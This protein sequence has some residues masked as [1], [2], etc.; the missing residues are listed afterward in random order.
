MVAKGDPGG[1]VCVTDPQPDVLRTP[2]SPFQGEVKSRNR[3]R[4]RVVWLIVA[5]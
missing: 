1:S 4:N 3:P 5:A 2:T